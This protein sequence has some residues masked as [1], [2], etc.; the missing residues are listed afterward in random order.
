MI[1]LVSER[2]RQLYPVPSHRKCFVISEFYL[3]QLRVRPIFRFA[4]FRGL[5]PRARF[6]NVADGPPAPSIFVR[7]LRTAS[8]YYG[9]RL[10][11]STTPFRGLSEPP[12]YTCS[13]SLS[14]RLNRR[15]SVPLSILR[16]SGSAPV[17]ETSSWSPVS[18]S[19]FCPRLLLG[20]IGPWALHHG[21]LCRHRVHGVTKA[22]VWVSVD[23]N[24][25]PRSSHICL[26]PLRRESNP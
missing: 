10:T 15:S 11:P 1:L 12:C 26:A 9:N 5:S 18:G 16:S 17:G 22:S 13:G 21:P 7:K 20:N 14:V 25:T 4:P 23:S 2:A 8:G 6:L 24:A 3:T 19:F